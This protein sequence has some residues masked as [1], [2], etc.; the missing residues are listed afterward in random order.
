LDVKSQ[1]S[2]L[3]CGIGGKGAE[4][5]TKPVPSTTRIESQGGIAMSLSH[6]LHSPLLRTYLLIVLNLLL[7]PACG[8]SIQRPTGL[9]S[10]YEDA[11]EMFKRGK[12]DRSVDFTDGLV[13][14]STPNKFTDRACVLRA[15]IFTGLIHAYK[16]I[17]DTYSKGAENSR[18]PRHSTEFVRLRHDNLQMG[19]KRA[20]GLG[21]AAQSLIH[22][23]M[24]PKEL[25]LE[26]PYPSVE[27]PI[28]VGEFVR[29]SEGGWMETEAQEAAANDAVRK[30]IDDSLAAVVG[31]DRAKARSALAG[32]STKLDG[33]DFSLYLGHGL[34]DGASLFD[35]KHIHDPERLR[36]LLNLADAS[37]KAGLALLKDNPDQAKEEKLKK[38]QGEIKKALQSAV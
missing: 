19:G 35:R 30:G 6:R 14:G 16:S 8:P 4:Y 12:F 25:T 5:Q 3:C 38:L 21:E 28:E 29:I 2:H 26:A 18:D 11:K 17:A 15:V 13:S 34:V 20:L 24:L 37:A 10:E 22:D 33:V 1:A 23:G 7:I 9:A 31:G 32:G 27:G 36:T